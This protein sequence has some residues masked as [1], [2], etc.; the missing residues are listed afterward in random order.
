MDLICGGM[1]RNKVLM[2]STAVEFAAFVSTRWWLPT[3][4]LFTLRWF[5]NQVKLKP[6]KCRR[7]GIIRPTF[8]ITQDLTFLFHAFSIHQYLSIVGFGR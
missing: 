1:Y 7:M 4:W 5:V 8:A 6:C 3:Q 2:A